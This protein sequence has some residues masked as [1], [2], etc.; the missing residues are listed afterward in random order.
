MLLPGAEGNEMLKVVIP[1]EIVPNEK[2]VAATPETIKKMM[3]KGL[4]VVVG[5]SAGEGSYIS[6][7][8]YEKAGATVEKDVKALLENADIVLK[9]Q[10]LT[11]DEVGL[12]KEGA[13][14]L[15]F[16][17]PLS[18]SDLVQRLN[19]K[20]ISA[21]S[22][23]LIPRITRAQTMD[24]LSSMA[25]V[26]GYKSIL[27]AANASPKLF[28][29]LMTAAGTIRPAKV[30][31][32]GA[33]VAG[34]QAIAIARR[35]GA[36]VRA[37]DTRPVVQ[38]QV[39]SLGAEFVSLGIEIKQEEAQDKGGYAK[40]LSADVHKKEQDLIRREV[41]QADVVVTTALIPGKKAPLLITRDMVEGMQPGSVIVDL[42]APQEGNC[43][44]TEPGKELIYKGIII[45]GYL[46]LPSLMPV[47]AS[48]M[49][50]RNILAFLNL[51]SPDG[52]SIQLNLADEII[53]G[54]LVTHQGEIVHPSIRE[55]LQKGGPN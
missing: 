18:H 53:K 54:S 48:Q 14:V 50:S 10:E 3:A 23:E 24:V 16:F 44:L 52:K 20:K 13:V 33:G 49:Y 28:P 22:M 38:E 36:V 46:N 27:L 42:A 7:A 4:Q 19:T 21:F 26:A 43:E 55:A 34:L 31:V 39:K 1:K 40:E 30:F 37:F 17:Q 15:S 35:L 25:T 41:T 29:L 9:V 47:P 12:L 45:L 11:R 6:N 8:D 32:I 5:V 51:L 2:R